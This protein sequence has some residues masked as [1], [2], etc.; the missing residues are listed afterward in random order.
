MKHKRNYRNP[1]L[2]HDLYEYE[3]GIELGAEIEKE[4]EV[5]LKEMK[6]CNCGCHCDHHPE[7]NPGQT[8]KCK[9]KK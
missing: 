8:N 4:K 6:H 7:K 3:M 1:E 9:H 2:T 5:H